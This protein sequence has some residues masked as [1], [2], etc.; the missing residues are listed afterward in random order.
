MLLVEIAHKGG[1]IWIL[2][3]RSDGVRKGKGPVQFG[4]TEGFD[5]P[6]GCLRGDPCSQGIY[7]LLY[8]M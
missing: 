4:V 5:K 3:R 1:P 8:P 6:I 2:Q 7:P